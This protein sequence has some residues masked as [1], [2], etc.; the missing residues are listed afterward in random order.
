MIDLKGNLQRILESYQSNTGIHLINGLNTLLLN[1]SFENVKREFSKSFDTISN[2]DNK[3]RN[4]VLNG[5]LKIAKKT[6]Q[7][8]KTILLE[9]LYKYSKTEAEKLKFAKEFGDK[10]TLLIHY[11]NKLKSINK[12]IE[13]G[14]RKIG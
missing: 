11:N 1:E 8:G 5:I 4:T 6:N 12:K 9:Y 13:Y 7:N 10:K 14:F 2:Y 3:E